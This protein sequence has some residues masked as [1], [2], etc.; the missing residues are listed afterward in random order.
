MQFFRRIF[1]FMAINILVVLTLSTLM[2]VLGIGPYLTSYGINYSAL[3]GFCLVWG[4]GGALISLAMSRVMAKWLMRVQ[5]IEPSERDMTLR[6]LVQTTHRLAQAAKL[7]VM[8]EVGVYDSPELN[9]FATGP[10]RSRALV[11]V[12]TGLLRGM[13]QSELEGVLAHEISHVANGDMVTMTLL[14]GVVNAFAMFLARALAFAITQAMNQNRDERERG[15]SPWVTYGIQMALEMVFMILGSLVV[16]W[17][18]RY[19]EYRADA[20]GASLA[21][22]SSMVGALQRLRQT[23]TLVDPN[24]QP[25]VQTLQISGH[26]RGLLALFASHPPLEQRIARLD[27][28]R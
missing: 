16:A 7:P 11:A 1:L 10:T 9:A 2:Q 6:A 22:R 15:T 21:G 8:P 13:S 24:S 3:A 28:T 20:G 5:V 12:S 14:Q 23:Y 25:A 26:P 17:F 4:M 19:R 18:S 27:P